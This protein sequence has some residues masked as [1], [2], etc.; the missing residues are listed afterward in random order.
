MNFDIDGECCTMRF[1]EGE[2]KIYIGLN[3]GFI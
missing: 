1:I 3:S 2:K